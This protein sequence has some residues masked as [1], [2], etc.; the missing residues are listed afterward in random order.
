MGYGDAL[1]SKDDVKGR[2]GINLLARM[3]CPEAVNQTEEEKRIA[4]L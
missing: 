1:N 2:E 4:H 3:I